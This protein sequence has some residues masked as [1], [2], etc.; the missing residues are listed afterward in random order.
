MIN[1]FIIP[2]IYGFI[3][4]SLFIAIPL[5]IIDLGISNPFVLGLAGS[6]F[7]IFYAPLCILQSLLSNRINKRIAI[8]SVSIT[9]PFIILGF[10]LLNNIPA[11]I[12]LC[13][14]M[15]IVLSMF[16]PAYQSHITIGLDPAQTTRNLQEFSIGWSSAGVIGCFVSGL[17]ISGINIKMI[18]ILNLIMSFIGAS[19]VARHIHNKLTNPT[20]ECT[21]QNKK[22]SDQSQSRFFLILA[23]IGVFAVF[24]SMGVIV[25]L[26]PKFATDAGM[27]PLIIG[28]LRAILGIFQVVMFFL[29]RLNHRWQYSFT[30][31]FFY[32]LMLISGLIILVFSHNVMWWILAFSLIGVSVGFLYSSSLFYSSQAR[33]VKSEKTGFH[34]AIIMSGSLFGTLLG[35][36]IA[37]TFSASGAYSMCI[38]F[39]TICIVIQFTVRFR[40]KTREVL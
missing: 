19:L 3:Q 9:Y 11:I 1:I 8:L 32:E 4:A 14:L 10:L 37:K 5:R 36:I 31:L 35:G 38:I 34:E 33:S 7:S 12:A 13:G 39:M 28:S 30:H 16:W 29:L 18:F 23:W 22:K 24:F 40:Y 26:F 6:V 15:G 25:W 27:S 2:F 17:I 20:I 21:T